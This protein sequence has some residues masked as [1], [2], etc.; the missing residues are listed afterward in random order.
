M[1]KWTPARADTLEALV[2]EI[3]HNYPRG[4]VLVAV[5][6]VDVAGTERFAEGLAGAFDAFGR[7]VARAS[8]NEFLRPAR[9]RTAAGACSAEEYYREAFDYEAFRRTLA[10]PFR[11]GEPFGL[12]G[13][14]TGAEADERADA[15]ADAIMLV[16]GVFLNRPELAGLWNYSI[17]LDS[18]P[19]GT[20]PGTVAPGVPAHLLAARELYDAESQ[21]RRAAAAIID[22]TDVEHPRRVFADAC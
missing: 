16:D 18:V 10:H 19:A 5:D 17:W 7:H 9:A 4:R 1:A 3:L 13:V 6:G 12:T 8:M 21:P 20:A 15:P 2:R 11:S 22:T 14:E